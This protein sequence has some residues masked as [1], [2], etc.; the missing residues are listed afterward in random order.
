MISC[1][2]IHQDIKIRQVEAEKMISQYGLSKNHPD[3][4][5]LDD[6]KL[7]IAQARAIQNFLNLKPYQGKNQAVVLL[8]AQNLTPDAQNAL[9]K[10][11]EEPNEDVIIILGVAREDQLLPTITSRCKVVNLNTSVS[12]ISTYGDEKEKYQKEIE[13]LLD[14]GTEERF[15]FIEKLE[16]RETFLSTL[17]F[18]FRKQILSHPENAQK[19][20]RSFLKD[21]LEAE[22]WNY[23]HVN[24]RAI[25]EYLMLR[26]PK[27]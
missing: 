1:L 14:A 26:M 17:I 24:I 2:L 25:L 27:K 6:E 9:L 13:K 7:G 4:F 19:Q 18:Y 3:L 11:L 5:W 10:T 16:D 15:Q 12:V 20:L 21:L 22:K 8:S 23:H